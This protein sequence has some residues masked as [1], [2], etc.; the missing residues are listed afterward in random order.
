MSWGNKILTRQIKRKTSG[1]VLL[2]IYFIYFAV[3]V[4]S[5]W[6]LKWV[7][8][9]CES[10]Q[11][12][13]VW[14]HP[15]LPSL[16]WCGL[17]QDVSENPQPYSTWRQS[18]VMRKKRIKIIPLVFISVQIKL[19][20]STPLSIRNFG[21]VFWKNGVHL[22]STA[23]EIQ[24]VELNRFCWRSLKPFWWLT[25]TSDLTNPRYSLLSVKQILVFQGVCHKNPPAFNS[26]VNIC[27]WEWWW[28][29]R[30]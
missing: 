24:Y 8:C 27:L 19:L 6:L 9:H 14:S 25:I 23:P 18:S 7:K 17:I 12:S 21:N 16:W 26:M 10:I 1:F 29:H 15:S 13:S 20:Y 5:H 3:M 28:E 30:I 4:W 2:F 22:S 11:S